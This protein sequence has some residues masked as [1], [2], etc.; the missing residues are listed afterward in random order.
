MASF[1][2]PIFTRFSLGVLTMAVVLTA[3]VIAVSALRGA[4]AGPALVEAVNA[5]P[6]RTQRVS[7]EAGTDIE[8]RFPALIAARRESAL[9]FETGGR[10]ATMAFDVGDR[11]EAGATLAILDTRSLETQLASARA[12]IAAALASA[13]LAAVTLARRRQ[14]V[15]QGHVSAQRL[16][17]ASADARSARAQVEA[18]RAEA[19]SLQVGIELARI[20]APFAGVITARSAD[21]GAIAAP[22]V[23]IFQ[24][25]ED[26][27]L[28]L[29][30]GLPQRDSSALVSGQSYIA[31]IDGRSVPVVFR[32]A[33]G[34]IDSRRRAVTAIFD[35]DPGAEAR[36]GEVAR[37]VLA[38]R[39]EDRGFWAPMTALTQG[40]RGLWSVYALAPGEDGFNL[41]PR[42]V[43]I[44]HIENDR[45]F[46]TGAVE[47]GAQFLSAGVHR[48]APGQSVRPAVEG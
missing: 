19:Q 21:E 5:L 17:E 22:G 8:T 3:I 2:L 24:L 16:D 23:A 11:V 33:T 37:L 34:V 36:S 27:A 9:G 45:V 20:D 48:V 30:A 12:R 1:R 14:L 18:A 29:R 13:E 7:F 47:D 35:L 42:P 43:E 44:L 6:V 31:E 28:E 32:A 40:R 38:T 39:L 4:E 25:V 10:I 46:L 15:E 26:G 41:E